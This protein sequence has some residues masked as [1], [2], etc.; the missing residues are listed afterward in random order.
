MPWLP[1]P[2][3]ATH[4]SQVHFF[5]CTCFPRSEA[6][7]GKG[8]LALR[9]LNPVIFFFHAGISHIGTSFN[10]R[11]DYAP[12]DALLEEQAATVKGALGAN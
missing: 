5:R 7:S 4:W 8:A 1:G 6:I 3:R 12:E 10:I 9:D 2:G 11:Q